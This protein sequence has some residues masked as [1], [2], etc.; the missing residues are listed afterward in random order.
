MKPL[1]LHPMRKDLIISSSID[2]N[3][4]A[5]KVWQAL[6]TPEIIK[7]YLFGTET[8]TDWK[9]GSKIVFTG[10]YQGQKYSDHGTILENIPEQKLSYTYWSAFT[11]LE[12]LPENYSVVSYR[13]NMKDNQTV[14]IWEQKGFA[15]EESYNHT[16]AG[17][18]S[19]LKQIKEI[20]ETGSGQ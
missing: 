12:D 14:L 8:I 9:T 1:T 13:L 3:A 19:V 5:K 16:L 20:V 11:G 17:I 7:K 10:E 18:S 6:V 15:S 4:T 2:I